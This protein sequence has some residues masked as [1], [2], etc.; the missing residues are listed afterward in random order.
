MEATA[1]AVRVGGVAG[2]VVAHVVILN[3]LDYVLERLSLRVH[4]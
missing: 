3:V 1:A 2:G 4:V